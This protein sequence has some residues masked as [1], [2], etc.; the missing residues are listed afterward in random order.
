NEQIANRNKAIKQ[1]GNRNK[2]SKAIKQVVI[3]IM[4]LNNELVDNGNRI[5]LLNANKQ[6]I[7]YSDAS[8]QLNG[9]IKKYMLDI[10]NKLDNFKQSVNVS[11]QLV[12]IDKQLVEQ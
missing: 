4:L 2:A 3:E 9:S 7:D 11:K 12:D 10:G 6:I 5:C 8:E 1:N